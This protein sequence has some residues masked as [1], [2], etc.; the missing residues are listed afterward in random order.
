MNAPFLVP[1]EVDDPG[2]ALRLSWLRHRLA[3]WDGM[4][5]GQREKLIRDFGLAAASASGLSV[6]RLAEGLGLTHSRVAVIVAGIR[7]EAGPPESE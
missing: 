3:S 2:A 7:A 5:I 6:R 4:T 1:P